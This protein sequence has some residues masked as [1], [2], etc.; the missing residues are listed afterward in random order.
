MIC[1]PLDNTPYEAKDM[2][3]YLA[4][5]TR[6]VFSS[7]G[8]LAVTPGESGLSVSVSPGLAWLKWS[9]YWG[10]AALQEQ[11]LTLA[12]DTA[13]GALK[14]I[15]AI[16]CRLDKVNNRAEIVVKKGAPSSAPIVV[17]PVRDAN[18]DELYIATVLIG[19]G[20]ISISASA[21]TDQRLNE[22]Y[23]GLMR[24]G[25]TGIPTASLHAQ[26]QQILTELT[27]ALNAQ[28]VRQSSEF[29]A[30]FE[31]LKGKLGED[32]ATALQQQVDNL[33]AAV[34]GDAFQAS[35]T[36][37]SIAYAGAQRIASIT[38]YGE[39]AQG[40][41]TEA[42]VAL[43]G[44][45]SAILFEQHTPI[46]LAKPITADRYGVSVITNA[47]GS[48]TV[49]GTATDETWPRLVEVNIPSAIIAGDITIS[50]SSP[51]SVKMQ[52]QAM[53]PDGRKESYGLSAG[54]TSITV[55]IKSGYTGMHIFLS[56]LPD[57]T[58]DET[59]HI[60][61]AQGTEPV[62]FV[63][64]V[65]PSIT[66]LPI[67]RPLH[68]VGDV[69]DIC[70][71]RVKSIYDKRIVLDGSLDE[72]FIQTNIID[73]WI[74]IATESDAVIP[75]STSIVGSI[76]S[77]YLKAYAI[78]EVY[79][80]KHSGISV[81]SNRRI[82]L[83]FKTSE[84]PDVTSVETARTY[85]SAHPLTV[86]YQ[87]TAYYGTNGL[88]VCLTEYQTDY[89]ESYA[90]ESIT[91]AWIS[92]TGELSTGAEVAYVLSSPETYAT[93]PLDFDNAAGPLTVMTGGEVEVRMTEL[94]GSRTYDADGDGVVDKAAAVPWDGVT[95]KPGTFAPSAHTH[96][97]RYYTET[98]MNTKL[99]GKAD[100]GHT[101]TSIRMYNSDWS[102]TDGSITPV[103]A[104]ANKDYVNLSAGNDAGNKWPHVSC[105]R[106]NGHAL[107]MSLSGTTLSITW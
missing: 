23:C 92:S 61:I 41:T 3:T 26:A 19:A 85:L 73:G 59:F 35:G 48:V 91:T 4:T 22:E 12:L 9:D 55:K 52:F 36:P 82:R 67:P 7:D 18:Y 1:F 98:E 84:Y 75:E 43:T 106:I 25:V 20:V 74:Q 28:I 44:V 46:N 14:R 33:N 83:S 40:G 87:S 6:G 32:P 21:I 76:K 69:R 104:N 42:P 80:K 96:D 34:V 105:Q 63:P 70:R 57:Q 90:G 37:V 93:E 11:A 54:S 10:T 27:D 29:D 53:T 51:A 66:H 5:R 49:K 72:A 15:D 99:N 77:S 86:Y 102:G 71:T 13:D 81:D 60:M 39:N 103:Y 16:V 56:L 47:D 88:D 95:G 17:P 8:N 31:E 30:W 2:G 38:A 64:Y 58:I 107:N 45:D 78:E 100:S 94:V 89:I 97:D 101:H 24:D 65:E 62:P 50:L 79:S 68:K